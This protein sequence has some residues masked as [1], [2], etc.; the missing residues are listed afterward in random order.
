MTTTNNKKQKV[1]TGTPMTM[2]LTRAELLSLGAAILLTTAPAVSFAEAQADPEALMKKMMEA[3]KNRSYEAFVSDCDEKVKS[4]L[5]KQMF[6]GVSGMLAPRLKQGWKHVYLG[7]LRQQGSI[8]H[9]WRLEFVD[10]KDDYLLR[11][12]LKDGKV[13]GI[14]VQ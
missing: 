14:F 5:T 2:T 8:T 4:G 13:T 1:R 9:L 10:G 6:E 12:S 11:M 3:T 7:K